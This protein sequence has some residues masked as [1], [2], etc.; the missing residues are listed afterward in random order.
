VTY[1]ERLR[2]IVEEAGHMALELR[3]EGLKIS[4]KEDGTPVTNADEAVSEFLERE[5][6]AAYP[7]TRVV[8]EENKDL[9]G[10][11]HALTWIVDPIDGTNKYVAG[12]DVW[13]VMVALVD[14]EPICSMV[15]FPEAN[16]CYWAERGRG[17][18]VD[19]DGEVTQLRCPQPHETL[20]FAHAPNYPRPVGHVGT[21][22]FMK[23]LRK[24]L[25]GKIDGYVRGPISY[26]DLM[27]PL[28]ILLEAGAVCTND[29]GKPLDLARADCKVPTAAIAHPAAHPALLREIKAHR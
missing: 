13:S 10:L 29:E 15:Y 6:V 3:A 7:E 24:L 21:H 19:I 18:F 28:C 14:T 20:R 8:S 27:P 17:A 11:T 16:V 25:W 22:G 4:M 12:R 5:L 2:P 1:L 23:H 9:S 26:W